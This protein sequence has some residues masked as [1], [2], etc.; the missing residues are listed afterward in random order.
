V[1]TNTE[2]SAFYRDV[3]AGKYR[4]READRVRIETDI[5]SAASEGRVRQPLR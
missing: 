2:I 4:S 1:W 5:I 3:T